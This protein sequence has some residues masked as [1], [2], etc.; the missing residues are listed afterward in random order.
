[1]NTATGATKIDP[2]LRAVAEK[3]IIQR[4]FSTTGTWVLLLDIVLLLVFT[5]ASQGVFLS[6]RAVDSLL[7]S[8]AQGLLL[9][10]GLAMLLGAGFFD[11]SLGANLVLSSV[12]GGLVIKAVTGPAATD[13]SYSNL[14]AALSLGALA[15]VGTGIMFG[16]V[17]GYLIAYLDVNSLIATLGT[18]G[19]GTGLAL[20]VAGGGDVTGLPRELQ[21]E[22]GQASLFDV[23]PIPTLI[24]FIA[25]ILLFLVL[26][27]TKYGTVT[28]AIGSSRPSAER[29]GLRVR[30]HI[31]SL[32][33][34]AGGL[35][36]VAGFIDISRYGSTAIAGH[37]QDALAAITAVVI[38][39]TLLEGGR[40]SIIGAIWGALLA[41]ILQTGLVVLGV[42][43]FYQLIAIGLVLIVA[44]ALDRLRVRR[45]SR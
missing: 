39:G 37:N 16:L 31:L 40:V 10:L 21:T 24:A 1:M 4:F 29:A 15:A 34:L 35:A 41:V 38:G 7:L 8:S 26:K 19:V 18:M 43:A 36:G 3:S 9:A 14:A 22:F 27:F 45:R 20:L 23:I 12:V 33:A 32:S 30:R 28:L 6:P 44:V 42:P 5:A 13:G 11:L 25:A 2:D 17:N